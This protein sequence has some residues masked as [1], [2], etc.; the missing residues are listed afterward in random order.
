MPDRT[1]FAGLLRL[2]PAD[3]LTTDNFAFQA[4]NPL[5]TD[6]LLKI[7]AQSHRHDQHARLLDPTADVT[8]AAPTG[9]GT[10]PADT[11]I[12]VTYT[13]L[14]ADGGE[15]LPNTTPGVISTQSSLVTP[16]VAP[17]ALLETTAGGLL[18]GNYSYALTVTDGAG[19]ETMLGPQVDVVIP[20]GYVNA[21]VA[22]S[23]LAAIVAGVG[24]TGWRL[25]KMKDGGGW[26]IVTFGATDSVTD[27]GTL[28]PDC[29]GRPPTS[30][31]TTNATSKLQITVPSGQPA[32]AVAFNIY[33]TSA[34]DGDFLSPSLL[35]TYPITDAGAMKEYTDLTLFPGAP[36][37]VSRTLAG[38]NKI[39]P[40][41]DMVQFP[42]K[43]PVA[44]VADLPP[45]G[46]VNGDIRLVFADRRLYAW[47]SSVPE[48]FPV[49]SA[50]TLT[51]GHVIQN[52]SDVAVPPEPKLVFKGSVAVTDDAPNS[53]TVVTVQGGGHVVQ[54]ED[55]ALPQR[56]ALDFRGAG[57]AATDDA[58]NGRTI[59]TVPGG[60]SSGAGPTPE[61]SPAVTWIDGQ[62]NERIR[63]VGYK[64]PVGDPNAF[65][66]TFTQANT[67]DMTY[68]TTKWSTNLF[69]IK[70]NAMV[71]RE[72][73]YSTAIATAM[74]E[75][76]T[77][78][79]YG[80]QMAPL[81]DGGVTTE[82]EIHAD[83]AWAYFG[84]CICSNEDPPL[85]AVAVVLDRVVREIQIRARVNATTTAA[86]Q[87]LARKGAA[88]GF[89]WPGLNDLCS[90][91]LD[92]S[93]H[94]SVGAYL[95][96][97]VSGL[98]VTIDPVPIPPAILTNWEAFVPFHSLLSYIP[99]H[100]DT[101]E[102]FAIT[103]YSTNITLYERRLALQFIKQGANPT[104]P[105]EY[106]IMDEKGNWKLPTASSR[107]HYFVNAGGG[108]TVDMGPNWSHTGSAYYWTDMEGMGHMAGRV[109]KTTGVAPVAGELIAIIP[110]PPPGTN[111]PYRPI[112]PQDF[113]VTTGDIDGRELGMISVADTGEIRWQGGRATDPATK[114]PFVSLDGLNFAVA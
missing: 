8:L 103:T 29:T 50:S 107:F 9:G 104:Y 113:V 58:T 98:D 101:T 97:S 15:T 63:L 90:L 6:R 36:P 23:G 40:D 57:V 46:N 22:L 35:G 72:D 31:R 69:R 49:G 62:N 105:D 86:W 59:V 27:D 7:A 37:A 2:D 65:S 54:D 85:Y 53:R 56:A 12:Y 77:R 47:D 91:S 67:T 82:F 16:E 81:A 84:P 87:I 79:V 78:P 41:T 108:G 26:Y 70:N 88:Q 24:G 64:D 96:N 21:Q 18:A 44:T 71:P 114:T 34:L 13:L 61:G 55:V 45:S 94:G 4:D 33:V 60:G 74:Y 106:N 51:P 75:H 100:Y 83:T 80:S 19:G 17:T 14:D 3:S 43:R 11:T 28:C 110:P 10:I 93:I 52:Q 20:P 92:H 38:A 112:Y 42:Y 73:I 109:R 95:Y 102:P 111:T 30:T 5:I 1:P 66:D 68:P 99:D 25:W 32:E 39:N 48:W 76:V 89:A